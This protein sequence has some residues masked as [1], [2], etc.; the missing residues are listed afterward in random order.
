MAAR[1]ILSVKYLA[2]PSAGAARTAVN[3]FVRYI[4]YRD[5]HEDV[6]A[7]TS[8]MLRYVGYRD[9][10]SVRGQLFDRSSRAGDLER[11]ALVAHV[12]R[13]LRDLPPSARPQRAVY[14]LVLSPADARGLDLRELAR[15][16]MCGLERDAGPL[17]PWVAAIHRNT[18][19][20]HVHIVMAA[21][22][23]VSPDRFKTVVITRPR[24]ARMK[25]S[26]A[27]EMSRQLDRSPARRTDRPSIFRE[28]VRV[29]ANIGTIPRFAS[30]QARHRTGFRSRV[31]ALDALSTGLRRAARR[32]QRQI[33]Q[34]LLEDE[35]RQNLE[36]GWDR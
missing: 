24:L 13:S 36:R 4:Q 15:A 7:D 22:R 10:T 20:P 31:G 1:A 12:R 14:R 8:R 29:K 3:G 9:P 5:H 19:H 21:R 11:K 18:Q 6:A 26:L 27:Q 16:T 28:L 25:E 32:Y 34:E 35:R 30:L 33:E 2:M 23:E 17:P